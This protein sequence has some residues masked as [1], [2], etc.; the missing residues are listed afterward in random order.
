MPQ[1]LLEQLTAPHGI[2]G[3]REFLADRPPRILRSDQ[4]AQLVEAHAEEILEAQD[5]ADA[6]GVGLRV[7][8]VRARA[9]FARLEQADLLVVADR[10]RRCA[11][12]A[13]DVA[14]AHQWFLR[15]GGATQSAPCATTAAARGACERGRSSDTTAPTTDVSASTAS[16][17]CML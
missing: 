17:T 13:R 11:H 6:L 1:R 16:A 2:L 10:P 15:A 9:P 14:D 3:A 12:R 4:L 7:L 8:A 5:L